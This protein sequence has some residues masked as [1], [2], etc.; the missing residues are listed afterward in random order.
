MNVTFR[1]FTK[2]D[3]KHIVAI[4]Q[5]GIDT[6]NATFTT[7]TPT[8]RDWDSAYSKHSRIV[9]VNNTEIVGWAA[10][11]PTSKRKVYEGVAEV[12]VYVN[13][14]YLGQKIGSKLLERLIQESENNNI[15]TLYAS[16]FPEN[17]ASLKIHTNLGFRE[18]GYRERIAKMDGV[19]RNTILIERR[20]NNTGIN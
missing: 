8:W 16:V 12:S 4:Y 7:E 10:L 1:F 13:T 2:K 20:S 11:S 15:W 17:Q 5:E 14:N 18:I 6:K 9:A 3:W 19:W